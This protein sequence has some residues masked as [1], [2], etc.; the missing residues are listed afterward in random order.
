[1]AIIGW[2]IRESGTLSKGSVLWIRFSIAVTINV[3]A[4]VARISTNAF[5]LIMLFLLLSLSARLIARLVFLTM[6]YLM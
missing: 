5:G 4:E 6:A 3:I 1:V 2:R